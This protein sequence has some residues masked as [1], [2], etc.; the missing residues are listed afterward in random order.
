MLCSP[1]PCPPLQFLAAKSRVEEEGDK[2]EA[3]L[4]D[5][6]AALF[7]GTQVGQGQG[8]VGSGYAR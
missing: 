2:G 3:P 8:K 6:M 7:M 4:D 1:A 5:L